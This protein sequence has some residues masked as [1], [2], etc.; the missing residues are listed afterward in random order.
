VFD[1]KKID[2]AVS[3]VERFKSRVDRYADAMVGV[4]FGKSK[5]K[6]YADAEERKS[7]ETTHNKETRQSHDGSKHVVETKNIK[8]PSK[9]DPGEGEAKAQQG[10]SKAAVNA[11]KAKMANDKKMEKYEDSMKPDPNLDDAKMAK[12]VS[13]TEKL[14]SRMDAYVKRNDEYGHPV[15][16][17]FRN[18]EQQ[19]RSDDTMTSERIYRT[20][21]KMD[22]KKEDDDD[23]EESDAKGGDNP[24]K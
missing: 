8:E 24:R 1:A 4:G 17:G 14:V 2:A 12:M 9:T 13:T 15:S 16:S 19:P 21:N 5:I 23:D 18:Q 6:N 10:E 11:L 22:P 7:K 20:I 3:A